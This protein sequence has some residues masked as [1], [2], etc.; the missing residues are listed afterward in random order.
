MFSLIKLF[1]R[2]FLPFRKSFTRCVEAYNYPS[3]IFDYKAYV[4]FKIFGKKLY[5][6][7]AKSC[8][9]SNE[10]LIYVGRNAV[11]GKPFCYI[12]G[13]GMVYIGHYTQLGPN[14]G[15]ISTNHDT[16][17]QRKAI[18]KNIIIGDYSWIGMGAVIT[19]GVE[20]GPRTIVGAN[21]TVTKSF[22]DGYCIIAGSPAKLIRKLTKEEIT[23][24][25]NSNE[26]YGYLTPAEFNEKKKNYLSTNCI[27]W[28]KCLEQKFGD[29]IK[30]Y[31]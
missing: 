13:G 5:W 3:F 24:Y 27:T 26:Y 31:E 30:D 4:F 9:I 25:H 16:Y 14:V 10:R 23:H 15:I 7:H 29:M 6:P 17:D 20:L 1:L 18:K 22:P 12:Q 28:G 21:S 11:V 2:L 19:A 8:L